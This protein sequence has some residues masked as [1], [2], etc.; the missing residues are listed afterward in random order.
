MPNR[1]ANTTYLARLTAS[2]E[3]TVSEGRIGHLR[4]V[5]WL[6]RVGSGESPEEAITLGL[7]TCSRLFGSLPG[8]EYRTGDGQLHATVHA[9]WASGA[10]AVISAGPATPGQPGTAGRPEIMLLG[11]SGAVYFDGPSGG[12]PTVETAGAS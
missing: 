1:P 5:R 4:F 9:V 3:K 6:D 8:R 10:S 2:L 11:S 12:T 7:D